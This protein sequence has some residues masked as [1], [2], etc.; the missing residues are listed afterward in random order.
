M[1]L[2]RVR[3]IR[4]GITWKTSPWCTDKADAIAMM[5]KY[6]RDYMQGRLEE[7]TV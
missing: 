3:Y 7:T 5:H 1:K 6:D 2:Y 4:G